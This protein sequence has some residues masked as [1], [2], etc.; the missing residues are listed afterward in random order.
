MTGAAL[1]P[2]REIIAVTAYFYVQFATRSR[3]STQ[4]GDGRKEKKKRHA[5]SLRRSRAIIYPRVRY[6]RSAPGAILAALARTIPDTR[7]EIVTYVTPGEIEFSNSA[8]GTVFH[9]NISL[10]AR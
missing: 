7:N 6:L 2:P 8:D 9:I 4:R 10:L 1:F 5:R 3:A